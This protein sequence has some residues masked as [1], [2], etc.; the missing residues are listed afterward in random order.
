MWNIAGALLQY[1]ASAISPGAFILTEVLA[2][3]A[4]VTAASTHLNFVALPNILP[5]VAAVLAVDILSQ[6]APQTRIA[7]TVQTIIHGTLYLVITSLCGVLAAY[8]TQRLGFPLQDRLFE[9][10]DQAI[11][12]N[13]LDVVT[14]VDGHARLHAILKLA[15]DSMSAQIALPVLVLALADRRF[16]VRQYLLSFVIALTITIAIAALLPATSPIVLVDRSTFHVMRFTGATPV[17]HLMLLREAGPMMMADSLGGIASF[18][19]FHA[20]VAVLTPLTLRGNRPVFAALLVLDAVM[21]CATITEGAHYASDVIA[22]AGVGFI[23]YFLAG[24]VVGAEVRRSGGVAD[25]HPVA[26]APIGTTRAA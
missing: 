8:A 13:W 21:L 17:D 20:T 9:Q 18:P 19:S 12:V 22:G 23:A 25:V 2:A 4:L 11:G 15:Y 1:R 5:Y 26:R 16:E 7:R 14:W 10:M 6:C 24:R 3:V